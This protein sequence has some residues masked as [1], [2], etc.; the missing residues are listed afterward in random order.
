MMNCQQ[1]TRRE[2]THEYAKGTQGEKN[3]EGTADNDNDRR[4]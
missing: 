2:L 1:V 3:H 4:D